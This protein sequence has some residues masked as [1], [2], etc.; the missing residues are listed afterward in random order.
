MTKEKTITKKNINH[1]KFSLLLILSLGLLVGC[2]NKTSFHRKNNR[3]VL[4]PSPSSPPSPPLSKDVSLSITAPP[5]LSSSNVDTYPV[6][7]TCNS[8]FIESVSID[9]GEPNIH[10]KVPCNSN[11]FIGSVNLQQIISVQVTITVTH[12]GDTQTATIANNLNHFI[13]KWEFPDDNYRFTIPLKP[14]SDPSYLKLSNEPSAFVY[15]FT[16]DWGDGSNP[17]EVTSFDDPDKTHTYAKAGTYII[18]IV[19]TCEGF[20]N[21]FRES[22]SN[23][24]STLLLEVINF[25]NM[26]WKDLSHAFDSNTHLTKFLGGDTSGVTDM[27]AMFKSSKDVIPDTSGWDTSN[28]TNMTAMFAFTDQANPDT[29]GWN[30]SNVTNMAGMFQ[31]AA[32]AN[33][34]T[35]DWDTSNVTSMHSMFQGANNVNPDTSGWN[36]SNVTNMASLFFDAH[37]ANPDTSGWDTSNVTN[38]SFMFHFAASAIPNTS[39]WNTSKV[40]NMANM[41]TF[42]TK[43]NPDTSG[44]N[45]SNVTDMSGLFFSATKANSDTSGWDTSKVT[46]MSAMFYGATEANSNTSGW[47]T[48]NVTNMRGMFGSTL[49]ANPNTS[50]WNTT[51]VTDMH[52]MFQ[53][54]KKANPDTSNWNFENVTDL[55]NIFFNSSLTS[56]NYSKFLISFN[57]STPT[58]TNITKQIDVGTLK[59]PSK[60]AQARTSLEGKGWTI[61]D[62]GTSLPNK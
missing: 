14:N 59:Y 54:A 48:S 4:N 31:D 17:S 40:T 33:P 8:T 43:A 25:G 29:N 10:L 52:L 46:D 3:Q 36:T 62:G 45:T 60:A 12:Q 22:S 39:D 18:R 57:Q 42:A 34:D 13:T 2:F 27:S 41:F 47:N 61:N 9:I 6:R 20:Q 58:S 1:K 49:N 56:E 7:G 21:D 44:W 15:N 35:S 5:P 51:R 26:G 38:M 30:T 50:Q 19:G 23:T 32:K 16:V 11:A 28:V 24:A 55:D 37:K 53:Y